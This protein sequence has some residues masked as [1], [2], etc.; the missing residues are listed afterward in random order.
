MVEREI[1][2]RQKIGSCMTG[3]EWQDIRQCQWFNMDLRA[4]FEII[5]IGMSGLGHHQH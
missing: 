4:P 1:N 3:L 5:G 2:E